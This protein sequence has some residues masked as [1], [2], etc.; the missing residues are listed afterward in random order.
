MRR[1]CPVPSF[2][3]QKAAT[4][5]MFFSFTMIR[6][7][8]RPVCGLCVAPTA[9]RSPIFR[10]FR[11]T[12][13]LT[14]TIDNE[15]TVSEKA[16]QKLTVKQLKEKI[17]ELDVPVKIS[18]LKLKRDLIN[19]LIEQL[20]RSNDEYTSASS[21]NTSNIQE[22]VQT[23]LPAKKKRRATP[24][25]PLQG[26]SFSLDAKDANSPK[27][28]VSP[29]DIIFQRVFDRYPS[30][31]DLKIQNDLHVEE[32]D[33]NFETGETSLADHLH[34][35][36]YKSFTGL[37]ELDIRQ[38]NHPVMKGMTSSDLDLITVGTA[39]CVPGVTRGVSCTALRLQWRRNNV[40]KR[41]VREG[42]NRDNNKDK[43]IERGESNQNEPITGGTWIFDCGES[44]QVCFIEDIGKLIMRI[45]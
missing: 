28:A 24:M 23:D 36:F 20:N 11:S 6:S 15:N 7:L 10:S 1:A 41:C 27:E 29:K 30:L 9:I 33:R 19:F 45:F 42:G 38:K 22:G 34:P 44:T 13:F 8:T 2:K 25:P 31:R 40:N 32:K 5:I 18:Q 3:G 14:S 21:T 43:G 37:G 26:R 39:S 4:I 16:L 17:K 35:S 12:T